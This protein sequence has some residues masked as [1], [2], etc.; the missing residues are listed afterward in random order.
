LVTGEEL[1][2]FDAGSGEELSRR[3]LGASSVARWGRANFLTSGTEAPR[4]RGSLGLWAWNVARPGEPT[5]LTAPPP[6]VLAFS[7]DGRVVAYLANPERGGVEVVRLDERGRIESRRPLAARGAEALRLDEGGRIESPRPLAAGSPSA[8]Q[9]SDRGELLLAVQARET[10]LWSLSERKRLRTAASRGAL[11]R[12][13][14]TRPRPLLMESERGG[15]I[16]I[17]EPRSGRRLARFTPRR[18][19]RADLLAP[20]PSGERLALAFPD[21]SLEIWRVPAGERLARLLLDDPSD[22]PQAMAFSEGGGRLALVTG[23]GR[24]LVF[25]LPS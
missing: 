13:L 5:R 18:H 22:P 24:I 19:T 4:G 12:F 15:R 7:G 21:G 3:A 2:S 1:V 16:Q 8:L 17:S 14:P 10:E 20:S 9:L 25:E 6:R 11:L 23:R